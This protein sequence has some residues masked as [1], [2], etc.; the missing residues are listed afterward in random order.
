[1][2][3]KISPERELSNNLLID[4]SYFPYLFASSIFYKP[5]KISPGIDEYELYV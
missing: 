4:I 5:I 2:E 3:E 1:M